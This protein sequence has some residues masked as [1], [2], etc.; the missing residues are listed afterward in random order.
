MDA[1]SASSAGEAR[2]GAVLEDASRI[3]LGDLVV[4]SA[5][6]AVMLDNEGVVCD[7]AVN[8][9]GVPRRLVESWQGRP[10]FESVTVESRPK[11][12]RLLAFQRGASR[13]MRTHINHPQSNAEDLPVRYACARVADRWLLALGQDLSSVAAAQRRLVA[14]QKLAEKDLAKL[15][16]TEARFREYFYLAGEPVLFIDADNRISAVNQAA[17]E[18]FVRQQRLIGRKATDLVRTGER[19]GLLAEL[20]AVRQSRTAR[21]FAVSIGRIAAAPLRHDGGTIL[22]RFFDPVAPMLTA[23]D[24]LARTVETMPDGF[25]VTDKD[26]EIVV[27]NEAFAAMA[28]LPT[29]DRLV[30]TSLDRF[31][32]R[33]GVDLSVIRAAL[34][35]D[36]KLKGY[37]TVVRGDLGR[38]QDVEVSATRV[39]DGGGDFVG[40]A[41]REA[42]PADTALPSRSPQQ[43]ADL[44][45]RI[46]MKEI[47]RETTDTIEQMCIEAALEMSGDNRASAAELLGLSRQSL[48]VKMR[49]FGIVEPDGDASDPPAA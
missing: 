18:A 19:E 25:V 16:N 48:Y 32:G 37:A 5:D 41:I 4:A 20:A 15:R 2:I 30:G 36:G 34:S 3:D 38:N 13:P 10:F 23:R 43:L 17:E 26:F 22:L 40:L 49:R 45:G 27:A 9:G 6:I 1:R 11:I 24:R 47:V 12:E 8:D 29:P 35:E 14:A 33:P 39:S 7:V 28:E 44:V 21:T 46:P 42:M 31:L